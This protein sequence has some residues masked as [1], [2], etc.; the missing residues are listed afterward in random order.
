[1]AQRAIEEVPHGELVLC[2]EIL[3]RAAVRT[4]MWQ[5]GVVSK[6]WARRIGRQSLARLVNRRKD[7]RN[8][9]VFFGQPAFDLWNVKIA[10]LAELRDAVFAFALNDT[11]LRGKDG[12]R[13]EDFG[14][15]RVAELEE[16]VHV[17]GLAINY[18][19]N[20]SPSLLVEPKQVSQFG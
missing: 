3:T 1:M 18:S 20:W 4:V 17:S 10:D 19:F 14:S 7:W 16:V 5:C 13:G 8:V 6:S 2:W 15:D 11:G 9:W 12:G